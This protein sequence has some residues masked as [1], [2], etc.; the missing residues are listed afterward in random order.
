[1]EFIKDTAQMNRRPAL[2]LRSNRISAS[3]VI[4][5]YS[6]EDRKLIE[7]VKA[8]YFEPLVVTID[9]TTTALSQK[10]REELFKIIE[11]TSK[12]PISR[13]LHF[14]RPFGGSGSYRS[15]QR[16]SDGALVK[17]STAMKSMLMN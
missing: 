1:M 11:S 4:D 3:T 15:H 2:T 6:F 8:T 13:H 16:L 14:P 17:L 12:R 9:E 10:G 7:I 5:N